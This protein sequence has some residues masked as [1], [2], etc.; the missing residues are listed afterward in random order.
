MYR[1]KQS[2]I[3]KNILLLDYLGEIRKND[4]ILRHKV[5]FF[6]IEYVYLD[7]IE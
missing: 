3:N 4:L 7:E 1:N 6:I 2:E 5:R